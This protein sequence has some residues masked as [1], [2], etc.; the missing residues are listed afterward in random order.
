[1]KQEQNVLGDLREVR[2]EM[3]VGMIFHCIHV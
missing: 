1:M 3:G 2:G